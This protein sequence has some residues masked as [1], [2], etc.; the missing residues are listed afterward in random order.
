MYGCAAIAGYQ[1]LGQWE[2]DEKQE[3]CPAEEF[4]SRPIYGK[5]TPI[6]FE[7]LLVLLSDYPD[8]FV[9]LDSKQYSVRKLSEDGG[10]LC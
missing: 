6:T 2:G 1:S 10:G 7:D 4:L 8:T 5:Y 3:F 9:M